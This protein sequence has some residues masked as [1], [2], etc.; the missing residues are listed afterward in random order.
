MFNK[1]YL[2]SNL[3]LSGGTHTGRSQ[4]VKTAEGGGWVGLQLPSLSAAQDEC[5]SSTTGTRNTVRLNY[6]F[7]SLFPFFSRQ[8]CTV[9]S[10]WDVATNGWAP[11]SIHGLRGG[12]WEQRERK[13][14]TG[15][16]SWSSAIL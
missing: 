15:S 4:G 10:A 12:S 16:G 5:S 13:N 11:A 14:Q 9:E 7:L 3:R 6:C 8:V 1:M 2:S